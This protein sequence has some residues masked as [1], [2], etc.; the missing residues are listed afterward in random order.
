MNSE[1]EVVRSLS[2]AACWALV[3]DDFRSNACE[4]ASKLQDKPFGINTDEAAL[5]TEPINHII[6][7]KVWGLIA[8]AK[9]RDNLFLLFSVEEVLRDQV[10]DHS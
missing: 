2:V 9:K 1:K 8:R 10:V 5:G 6:I 7:L 4:I 3:A